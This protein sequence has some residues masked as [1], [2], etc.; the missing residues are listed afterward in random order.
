MKRKKMNRRGAMT[1]LRK[2]HCIRF[3][4]DIGDGLVA[5]TQ[6]LDVKDRCDRRFL[7]EAKTAELR[8]LIV[9]YPPTLAIGKALSLGLIA[10]LLSLLLTSNQTTKCFHRRISRLHKICLVYSLKCHPQRFN[11]TSSIYGLSKGET[12]FQTH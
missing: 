12:G 10:K 6:I 11:P 8:K 3:S 4:I 5:R 2:I 1:W 9:I 7:R